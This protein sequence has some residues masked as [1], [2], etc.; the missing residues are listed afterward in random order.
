VPIV[1]EAQPHPASLWKTPLLLISVPFSRSNLIR[2]L[3]RM[4][5]HLQS[6]GS[7]DLLP[8]SSLGSL[9][10][11]VPESPRE[12]LEIA[13]A[14]RSRSLPAKSLN[15]PV[16]FS[17]KRRRI[18]TS[19]APGVLDVE[20]SPSTSPAE[21]VRLVAALSETT[22]TFSHGC[23]LARFQKP[24]GLNDFFFFTEICER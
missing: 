6:S 21:F 19:R 20:T 11:S 1:S 23:L 16:V 12:V 24:A 7:R 8:W 14:L 18:S 9:S 2:P 3:T 15:T 5:R 10:E 13:H 17:N 4:S 22:H